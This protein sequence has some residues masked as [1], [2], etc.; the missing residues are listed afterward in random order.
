VDRV[1]LSGSITMSAGK[2]QPGRNSSAG[3][4]TDNLDSTMQRGG[5]AA[6]R[7]RQNGAQS[8]TGSGTWQ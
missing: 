4:F 2:C 5:G 1:A 6:G 7:G 8:G 3:A